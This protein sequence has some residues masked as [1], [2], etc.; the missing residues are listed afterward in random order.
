MAGLGGFGGAGMVGGLAGGA[1]AG[2]GYQELVQQVL[3]QW[4]IMKRVGE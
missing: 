2:T 4:L 3:I 1:A